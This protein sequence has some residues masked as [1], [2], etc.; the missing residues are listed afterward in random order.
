MTR[1]IIS[2]MILTI[3]IFGVTPLSAHDE[4]RIVGIIAKLQN[5]KLDVKNREGKTFTVALNTET[6]ISR[7]NQKAA[8]SDLK[9]GQSV[10]VDALGD[11]EADLV[12]LEVR[13]VPAIA[14]SR[15]K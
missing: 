7:D 5:S 2:L 11:S 9:P 6:L 13:I 12:A 14:P 4:F 1:R 10:V 15:P 3:M 8:V